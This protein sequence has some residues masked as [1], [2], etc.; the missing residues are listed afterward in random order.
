LAAGPQASLFHSVLDPV[1][2]RKTPVQSSDLEEPALGGTDPGEPDSTAL[3]LNPVPEG[4]QGVE[5]GSIA[6]TDMLKV[7]HDGTETGLGDC[8]E[9]I[10]KCHR[11]SEIYLSGHGHDRSAPFQALKL[12]SERVRRFR[13]GRETATHLLNGA[14]TRTGGIRPMSARHGTSLTRGR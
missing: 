7:H 13:G 8:G 2:Q 12:D 1:T 5:A 3:R 10:T 14:G 9:V 6:E 11:G 4:D